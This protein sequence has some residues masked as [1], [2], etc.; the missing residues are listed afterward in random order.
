MKF[1]QHDLMARVDAAAKAPLK[2]AMA[3]ALVGIGFGMDAF[4]LGALV[5]GLVGGPL[6]WNLIS[7]LIVALFTPLGILGLVLYQ[8][9]ARTADEIEVDDRGIAFRWRNGRAW[10]L[11]WS[12][13]RFYL[14]LYPVPTNSL[15]KNPTAG[16]FVAGGWESTSIISDEIFTSIVLTAEAQGMNVVKRFGSE[17]R[18]QGATVRRRP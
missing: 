4:Q 12:D 18:L 6:H 10:T 16:D 15:S 2:R 9:R 17:G 1:D 5:S 8:I 14:N 3:L 7:T 11:E 13:P